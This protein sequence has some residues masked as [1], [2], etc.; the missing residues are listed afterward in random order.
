MFRPHWPMS[1][2]GQTLLLLL[3]TTLVVYLGAILGYRVL[4]ERAAENARTS[5]IAGRLETAMNEL[6]ALPAEERAAAAQALSSSNFR[7]RWG[8]EASVED[9]TTTDP[10]LQALREQLTG[11]VPAIAEHNILLRWDKNEFGAGRNTLLGTA[12]LHDGSYV[13]FS[14][15]TIPTVL[16]TLPGVLLTGS[17]VFISI[18]VVAFLILRNIN[19]PLRKLAAAADRYG[20]DA[21]VFLAE[22]GPREIV[23]VQ[24]AFNA[25]ESRIHRLIVDRTQALAAVS[26]DLRAPIARLRLRCELL[27]D[28][29]MQIEWERDLIEMETMIES[30]LA[31]LRGDADTE[32]PRLTDLV[33]LLATLVDDAVDAGKPATLSGPHHCGLMLHVVSV[34]RAFGNLIDNAVTYGSSVDVTIKMG[35]FD[36]RTTIDDDGPGIPDAEIRH[37][38]EP[39]RRFEPSRD[40]GT[41]GVG[42][43]LTIAYQAFE[44]EG[45]SLRLMNRANGGLRAEV[46]L[47]IAQGNGSNA[48][49]F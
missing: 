14:T 48:S 20:H 25:M 16:P 43:G 35:Q 17:V 9:M 8:G 31:F 13:M 44:R 4:V 38:F 34:K 36:V 5:Q 28:R 47:P 24:R 19:I 23:K 12:R 15:E 10:K 18:I 29:D 49:N 32:T 39:F 27:S 11:L 37:A 42:L 40:R 1:L 41:G 3:V 6:A 7:L 21:R 22:Q 33:S 45:G 2:A 46:I 26:H 30:T